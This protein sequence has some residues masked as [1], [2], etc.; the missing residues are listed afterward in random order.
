VIGKSG[1][2]LKALDPLLT[3]A[4]GLAAKALHKRG[5]TPEAG[6]TLVVRP[7]GMGDLV[8]NDLAAQRLGIADGLTW[9]I[10][11]RSASWAKYRG[12]DYL[13]YDQ[14]PLK[15]AKTVAS[16]YPLVINTEQRF[17]LSMSAA[18]WAVAK[19]GLLVGFQTNRGARIADGVVPY[20]WDKA[21][22]VNEFSRIL[23]ATFGLP[24]P[25]PIT[26]IDRVKPSDGTI[27][28]ALGGTHSESRA[29]SPQDW[30]AWLRPMIGSDKVVLTAG[31]MERELADALLDLLNGQAS[32][33]EG[34]FNDLCEH[35][36]TSERI[37]TIDGGLV[38]VASFFGVPCDVLFTAGRSA[39]WA[40]L[41]R[42]SRIHRR[43]DLSC[44][45]CTVYGQVPACPFGYL[46]RHGIPETLTISS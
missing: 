35:I 14:D 3:P 31:P 24:F 20:D 36:A 11:Q 32:L 28:V 17:G 13:T 12:L 5:V 18:R 19:G 4:F 10:E 1:A 34:K 43:D 40:P 38:H 6:R 7:G 46:C 39:K 26:A 25:E 33:F 37:L 29:L 9:L 27:T 30:V 45:P 42:G 2:G 22:E 41:G 44:Q 16:K 8:L 21:H 23:A 15:A